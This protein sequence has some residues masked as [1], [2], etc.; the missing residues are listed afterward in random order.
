[1]LAPLQDITITLSRIFDGLA[2]EIIYT[3][4]FATPPAYVLFKIMG[5]E[6]EGNAFATDHAGFP[7][8]LIR[9]DVF[10]W[11]LLW[12]LLLIASRH[13]TLDLLAALETA[14]LG[15]LIFDVGPMLLVV[16]LSKF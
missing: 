11:K 14:R 7:S 4:T 9:L 5:C 15:I 10:V 1:M 16:G 6:A 3:T 13:R 8:I 2:V 12:R